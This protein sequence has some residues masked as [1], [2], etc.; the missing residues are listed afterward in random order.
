MQ[1]CTFGPKGEV[2]DIATLLPYKCE[3]KLCSGRVSSLDSNF[4][5]HQGSHNA[6]VFVIFLL[7]V[8]TD[9]IDE[10]LRRS[11]IPKLRDQVG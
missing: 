2:F 3:Q 1:Q 6:G 11:E 10:A 8:I 5:R 4:C 7:S 9:P